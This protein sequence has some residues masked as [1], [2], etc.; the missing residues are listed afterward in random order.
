MYAY[1]WYACMPCA[2]ALMHSLLVY[3]CA[4][5]LL[6]IPGFNLYWTILNILLFELHV[7]S[8]LPYYLHVHAMYIPYMHSVGST[9]S[10]FV[11][12]CYTCIVCLL[13]SYSF[14]YMIITGVVFW[15]WLGVLYEET[16]QEF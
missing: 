13:F 5:M 7:S 8:P 10:Q 15:L 9:I 6:V 14:V 16:V 4:C 1:A 3:M 2:F 11:V 12:E